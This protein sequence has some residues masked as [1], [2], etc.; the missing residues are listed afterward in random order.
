MEPTIDKDFGVMNKNEKLMHL[1]LKRYRDALLQPVTIE[2]RIT[3]AITCLESLFLEEDVELSHRL[4]QRVAALLRIYNLS[5]IAVYKNVKD[6][7]A[8]RS[9]YI[10]GA[11]IKRANTICK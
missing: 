7:Y 2:A 10:H 1:T 3:S 9:K 11:E 4:S 8:I 6:A 5:P